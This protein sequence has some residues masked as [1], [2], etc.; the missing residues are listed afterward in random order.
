MPY[1]SPRA[2]TVSGCPALSCDDDRC[3]NKKQA[4]HKPQQ[5]KDPH[6]RGGLSRS[7]AYSTAR[8]SRLRTTQISKA[9]L[10]QRCL[11]FDIVTIATDVDHQIP[12]K[13][14]RKLMWNAGNLQSL[15]KSCHSWKTQEELKGTYHDFR[16]FV[17]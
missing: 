17:A 8:W 15:C 11:S 3:L 7:K 1:S 12:H 2:C 16:N 10:C 5:Q 9:P 13:G 4:M 14:D 6:L